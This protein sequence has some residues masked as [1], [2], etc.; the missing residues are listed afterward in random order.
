MSISK[1]TFSHLLQQLSSPNQKFIPTLMHSKACTY[2]LLESFS[3]CACAYRLWVVLCKHVFR[4]QVSR[5][6]N[7]LT[8]EMELSVFIP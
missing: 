4:I 6:G 1:L 2:T 3:F 7:R 8:F 5:K